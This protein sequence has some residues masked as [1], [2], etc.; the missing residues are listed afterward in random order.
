M[1][2][3]SMS[4]MEKVNTQWVI[5]KYKLLRSLNYYHYTFLKAILPCSFQLKI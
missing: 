3:I 1:A 2:R 5:Q 4:G